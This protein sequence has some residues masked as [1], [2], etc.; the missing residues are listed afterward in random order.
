[1]PMLAE[2]ADFF[3]REK[4]AHTPHIKLAPRKHLTPPQSLLSLLSSLIISCQTGLSSTFGTTPDDLCRFAVLSSRHCFLGFYSFFCSFFNIIVAIILVIIIVF[5]LSRKRKTLFLCC[6]VYI[7][8][9]TLNT[10][11]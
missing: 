2:F 10:M 6:L 11:K 4:W 5:L 8:S 1:M 9:Y 3:S 7:F